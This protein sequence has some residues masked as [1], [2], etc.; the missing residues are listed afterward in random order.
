MT[1]RT[2]SINLIKDE[3][4]R[5]VWLYIATL[6]LLLLIKPARVLMTIDNF[7][8]WNTNYSVAEYVNNILYCLKYNDSL[9]FISNLSIAIIFAYVSFAFLYSRSRVDLYHSLPISRRK[10]YSSFAITAILPFFLIETF[11]TIVLILEM[12]IKNL[13]YSYVIKLIISTYFYN[14]VFFIIFFSITI[15]AISVTG[16][17]FVGLALTLLLLIGPEIIFG[18][19]NDYMQ[20]CFQT[21]YYGS[22]NFAD[23][24]VLLM[25]ASAADSCANLISKNTML[26]VGFVIEALLLL[27]FGCYLYSIR[28]SE[29]TSQAICYKFLQPLIRIPSVAL[30]ALFG[31]IYVVYISGSLTVTWYWITFFT[32]AIIVQILLS[33]IFYGDFRKVY[34]DWI[35]FIVSLVIAVIVAL[36]FLYDMFGYDRY[37]PNKDSIEYAS[38]SLNSIQGE[39]TN[40]DLEN[41]FDGIE[42]VYRDSWAYRLENTKIYDTDVVLK[43]AEAGINNLDPTVSVF[44]RVKPS[45]EAI[46]GEINTQEDS[47]REEN[48]YVIKYHLKNGRDVYRSYSAD[49]DLTYEDTKKIFDSDEYKNGIYQFDDIANYGNIEKI[50]GNDAWGETIFTLEG[51]D[52]KAFLLALKSDYME[53]GLDELKNNFPIANISSYLNAGYYN[54]SLYGYYI[55]P[56]CEK[57]IDLLKEK[58]YEIDINYPKFDINRISSIRVSQYNNVNYETTEVE[59]ES[60]MDDAVISELCNY[61]ILDAFAYSNSVLKNYET[62]IDLWC[63]YVNDRG[64]CIEYYARIPKGKVPD[65]VFA[66]LEAKK[67]EG[68]SN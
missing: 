39:I 59:Y 8:A 66:D 64:Y 51:D 62:S 25:P 22:V 11:V 31:G 2:L 29:C 33:G 14:L 49:I 45:D 18:I 24:W 12:G 40:Y 35:Q 9:N 65:R 52:V 68:A 13:K 55:Y 30:A 41:G 10:I 57:T 58:G 15:I 38:I 3:T 5:K 32:V 46:E 28:P 27:I 48:S 60:G 20:F 42:L 43:L 63:S 26:F 34:K 17:R 1:S 7:L 21:K 44:E 50:E 47:S 56:C 54:D 37:I 36:F 67:N 6:L 19:F 4:K 61:M 23:F 53:M 16:N